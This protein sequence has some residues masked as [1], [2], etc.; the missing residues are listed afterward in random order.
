MRLENRLNES[1]RMEWPQIPKE[2]LWMD[3]LA[4]PDLDRDWVPTAKGSSLYVGHICLL[5]RLHWR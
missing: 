5:Q 1:R 4:L 2:S 3:L